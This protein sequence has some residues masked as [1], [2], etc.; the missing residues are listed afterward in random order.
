MKVTNPFELG[1]TVRFGLLFS[2]VPLVA[3]AVTRRL[4]DRETSVAG[5]VTGR[6]KQGLLQQVAA[7]TVLPA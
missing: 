3:K 2:V 1:S 7:T 6:T 5:G 4:G